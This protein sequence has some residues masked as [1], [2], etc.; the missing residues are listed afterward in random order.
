MVYL[1]SVNLILASFCSNTMKGWRNIPFI[2]PYT[3]LPLTELIKPY[4]LSIN[5]PFA[6]FGLFS[7]HNF[8]CFWS[9]SDIGTTTQFLAN[10]IGMLGSAIRW[11]FSK[12]SG[13]ESEFNRTLLYIEA[14]GCTARLRLDERKSFGKI[15]EIKQGDERRVRPDR[16]CEGRKC[17]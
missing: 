12:I 3:E 7:V 10:G 9:A 6:V 2:Y 13:P 8:H 4:M 1:F 16:N 14:F 15:P 11:M 5:L 17:N